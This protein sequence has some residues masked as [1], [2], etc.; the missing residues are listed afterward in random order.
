MLL[1]YAANLQAAAANCSLFSE[2]ISFWYPRFIKN[3][4]CQFLSK[5]VFVGL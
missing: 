4:F 3:C 2:M 1:K 5:W